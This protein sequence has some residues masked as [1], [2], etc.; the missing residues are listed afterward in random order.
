MSV[1]PYQL[2]LAADRMRK[3]LLEIGIPEGDHYLSLNLY[4]VYA[5]ELEQREWWSTTNLAG[6]PTTSD[7]RLSTEEKQLD[8]EKRAADWL[9]RWGADS[10]LLRHN[11]LIYIMGQWDDISWKL[12]FGQGVC[13]KV[14]VGTR[15]VP[16]QPA[17]PARD[18]YEEPIYEVICSDPLLALQEEMA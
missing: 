6:M 8:S 13:E 5:G 3:R 17:Q 16:A 7:W 1:T 2:Y 11:G 12:S 15:T 4:G 14:Q 10:R 9:E 18:A